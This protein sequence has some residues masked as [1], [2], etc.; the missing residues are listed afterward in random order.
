MI[1]LEK[2]FNNLC[3]H[4]TADIKFIEKQFITLKSNYSESVRSYHN[5]THLE[6]LFSFFDTYENDLAHPNEV[7]FAIFY[8]DI[9]YK[10]GARDNEEK[11]VE[12]AVVE[13]TKLKIDSSAIGRI[14]NLI[15]A[16]KHH[17]AITEDE[18][19]MV[20]LD[21]SILG[22][23]KDRYE[24]YAQNIRQEYRKIPSILYKRGRKKVL[25]HFLNKDFIF[26]TDVFR[27]KFESTA[28]INL[29]SE[30]NSL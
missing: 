29:E 27:N 19:W 21:L 10:I 2:R 16:T 12:A 4:Y 1:N 25:Q 28:R 5:L 13:L 20:D 11:S 26:Q 14:S 23:A 15:M 24:S 8:H 22:Q 6:A 18:K 3:M 17:N 7:A 30:L 9:I